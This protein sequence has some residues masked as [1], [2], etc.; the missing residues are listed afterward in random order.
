MLE[1]LNNLDAF[2][3]ATLKEPSGSGRLGLWIVLFYL[4][5]FFLHGLFQGQLKIQKGKDGNFHLSDFFAKLIEVETIPLVFLA[6]GFLPFLFTVGCIWDPSGFI[7]LDCYESEQ[8]YRGDDGCESCYG[9]AVYNPD[10]SISLFASLANAYAYGVLRFQV[11][12]VGTIA[13]IILSFLVWAVFKVLR[14]IY[15]WMFKPVLKFIGVHARKIPV[16]F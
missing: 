5:V 1:F 13:V 15:L 11:L 3:S 16:R 7:G 14:L 6:I 2:L 12:V 10:R 4:G 8:G 9:I